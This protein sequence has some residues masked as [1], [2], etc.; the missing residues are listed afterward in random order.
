MNQKQKDRFSIDKIIICSAPDAPE[1][2]CIYVFQDS[3]GFFYLRKLVQQEG[4]ETPFSSIAEIGVYVDMPLTITNEFTKEEYSAYVEK[5]NTAKSAGEMSEEEIQHLEETSMSPEH[6]E[7][8]E[9]DG[10]MD[11]RK[12]K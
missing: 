7:L 5:I 6:D 11:T 4:L 10:L 8:D 1:D 9:I 3:S 2:K 12:N